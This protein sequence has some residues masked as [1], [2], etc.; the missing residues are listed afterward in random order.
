V[1]T[2]RLHQRWPGQVVR[3]L[4]LLD[5]GVDPPQ[6]GLLELTTEQLEPPSGRGR[7]LLL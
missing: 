7:D 3:A 1:P 2:C 4:R 5:I 6:P